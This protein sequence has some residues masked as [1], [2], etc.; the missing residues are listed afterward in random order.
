MFPLIARRGGVLERPGHT[1]AASELAQLAGCSPSAVI[2]EVLTE[3][4]RMAGP[5]ALRSFAAW[6]DMPCLTVRD[7]IRFRHRAGSL[8]QPERE[9]W[10]D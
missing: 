7:L 5:D 2:G 10:L 8:V 4:G 9:R 6:H 1:E 3:D